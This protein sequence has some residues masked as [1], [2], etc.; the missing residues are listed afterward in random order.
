MKELIK[1]FNEDN[2]FAKHIDALQFTT[3]FE[4]ENQL[5]AADEY[6]AREIE[7]VVALAAQKLH[8]GDF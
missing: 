5:M 4:W 7:R 3:P 2:S 8:D 6:L 1:Q